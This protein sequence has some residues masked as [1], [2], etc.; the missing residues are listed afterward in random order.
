MLLSFSR[1][2]WYM[3][4]TGLEDALG[5]RDDLQVTRCHPRRKWGKMNVGNALHIERRMADLISFYFAWRH[6]TVPSNLDTS[7]P[8]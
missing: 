4:C 5:N 8:Y 1:D 6:S 3:Y 2:G 7:Q